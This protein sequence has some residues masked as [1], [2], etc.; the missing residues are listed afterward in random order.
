MAQEAQAEKKVEFEAIKWHNNR[1]KGQKVFI[2]NTESPIWAV[3]K[4]GIWFLWAEKKAM[5]NK[6]ENSVPKNT[7]NKAGRKTETLQK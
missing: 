6:G 7:N 1:Q 3:G 4:N 2:S 5:Q